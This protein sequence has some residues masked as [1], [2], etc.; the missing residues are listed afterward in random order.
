[1]KGHHHGIHPQRPAGPYRASMHVNTHRSIVLLFFTATF[2]ALTRST[3]AIGVWMRDFTLKRLFRRWV[4]ITL[5]REVCIFVWRGPRDDHRIFFRQKKGI[6]R[7]DTDFLEP[8]AEFSEQTC[9]RMPGSFR[10]GF[11]SVLGIR[12]VPGVL[13]WPDG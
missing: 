6:S 9:G 11:R 2:E 4:T 7:S 5:K 3:L 13:L 1:M 12:P 8:H 10:P